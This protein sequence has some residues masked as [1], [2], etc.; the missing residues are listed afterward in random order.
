M[1]VRCPHCG[2]AQSPDVAFVEDCGSTGIAIY[3]CNYC[4][5]EFTSDDCEWV[6]DT[7]SHCLKKSIEKR[8]YAIAIEFHDHSFGMINGPTDSLPGLLS[9][10]GEIKQR[11]LLLG[12]D[13]EH[14]ILFRYHNNKWKGTT[15][16]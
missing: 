1:L 2:A 4:G 16:A 8:M 12:E 14:K 3:I 13:G 11:I 9:M 10:P 6:D 15:Y 5:K 7:E